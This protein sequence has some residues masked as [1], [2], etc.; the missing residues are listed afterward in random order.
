MRKPPT[1]PQPIAARVEKKALQ[2]AK[3]ASTYKSQDMVVKVKRKFCVFHSVITN[4]KSYE[5]VESRTK[6]KNV[7]V[8]FER[9]VSGDSW[10]F[11]MKCA[12]K[13]KN[14]TKQA[15]YTVSFLGQDYSVKDAVPFPLV[16]YNPEEIKSLA[17]RDIKVSITIPKTAQIGA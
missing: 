12:S 11:V 13:D 5:N 7:D 17:G 2:S 16:N 14:F 3:A 10:A 9:L 4:P 15:M 6:Q 8:I 1:K